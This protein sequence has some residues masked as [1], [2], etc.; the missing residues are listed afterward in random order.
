M[1]TKDE[2][3]IYFSH[4]QW[5]K[6]I[7]EHS[8]IWYIGA[9]SAAKNIQ[10]LFKI[11]FENRLEEIGV[12]INRIAGNFG[13]I[14]HFDKYVV[15]IVDKIRSFP[16][17]YICDGFKFA[18][19][20]SASKL[21]EEYQL[22]EIDDVALIEFAMAGYVTGRGTVFRDLYQIQAG[23]MIIWQKDQNKLSR[24]QYYKYFTNQWRT[25][26]ENDLVSEL[27]EMTDR[28][29]HGVI[30]NAD[31]SPIWIPLSGG[32]D[33][34]LI[35]C[36]LK[37]LGYDNLQ[38]YSY[39]LPGN[40]EAKVA[41][42]V[43]EKL[44]VPWFFLPLTKDVMRTFF[45]SNERKDYW[46]FS[47]G[48]CSVPIIQDL[49]GLLA[50][51]KENRIPE[52]VHI[53]NGQSGDFITGGHIPPWSG[54]TPFD[55][56]M[57]VAH[58][59]EKHFSLWSHLKTDRNIDHIRQRI[60]EILGAIDVEVDSNESF[61][62][63]IEYWEWQER[64]SKY[65]VNEQRVYD[66]L[67]TSWQLPLWH[68]EYLAFWRDIPSHLKLGQRLYR[69]YL[70]RYDFQG[71]FK[72]YRPIVWRWPGKSIGIVGVA[73]LVGMLL[74][75]RRKDEFYDY[76]KYYGHYGCFYQIYK[77]KHFLARAKNARSGVSF[78]VETWLNEKLDININQL[79]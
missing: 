40:H 33:S 56:N 34:R 47:D 26:D 32:L 28:V 63:C 2:Q 14:I 66:Y 67:G 15:A 52:D 12:E 24:Y 64:Q 62:K 79:N 71:L 65:V 42:H 11:G 61:S 21:K 43:A 31:G 55:V 18:L 19:S 78:Y 23:E 73:Q 53:I 76:A 9:S 48:L 70:E 36:K 13:M 44:G 69:K 1:K 3:V 59:V 38:T 30:D 8:E 29:F 7:L 16:I 37:E 51:R 6:L 60:M 5:N 27:D 17:F 46:D 58:L 75:D 4:N 49:P 54:K 68:D 50:L 39:G 74:G 77:L 22:I 72:D 41:R 20:N 57:V 45:W 10:K 25:Q 35:A